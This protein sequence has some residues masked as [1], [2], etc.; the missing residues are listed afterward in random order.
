MYETHF[1]FT[2]LQNLVRLTLKKKY[3]ILTIPAVKNRPWQS[4]P[5]QLAPNIPRY[6]NQ[7]PDNPIHDNQPL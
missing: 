7:S 2:T 1:L 6:D 4:H 5:R 3:C